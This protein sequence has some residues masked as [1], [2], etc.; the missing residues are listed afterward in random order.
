DLTVRIRSNEIG[1]DRIILRAA[2]AE[3]KTGPTI[4]GDDIAF[5]GFETTDEIIMRACS[6]GDASQRVAQRR[7]SV[8]VQPDE[9]ALH[10]IATAERVAQEYTRSAIGSDDV[11]IIG[12][13]PADG[14]ILGTVFEQHSM[15]E[16]RQRL[17]AGHVCPDEIAL[18]DN[19]GANDGETVLEIAG[20]DIASFARSANGVFGPGGQDAPTKSASA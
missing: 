12:G 15:A 3:G 10:N 4:A 8:G 7:S 18:D 16:V 2:V 17:G 1:L 20:D 9:I 6:D 13:G 14:V 5:P 19:V 11:S